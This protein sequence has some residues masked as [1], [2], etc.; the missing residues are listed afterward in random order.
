MN[1]ADFFM[2]EISNSGGRTPMTSSNYQKIKE[3]SQEQ[4]R[5]SA[6][7]CLPTKYGTQATCL[8]QLKELLKRAFRTF[9]RTPINQI[10][11]SVGIVMMPLFFSAM[12]YGIGSRMPDPTDE[13][14]I[15]YMLDFASFVFMTTF[16]NFGFNIYTAVLTSKMIIT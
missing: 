13:D 9:Y 12:F 4:E 14:F 11:K 1:P 6:K 15:S 3:K 16:F 10:L 5:H 7:S 8:I 2:L